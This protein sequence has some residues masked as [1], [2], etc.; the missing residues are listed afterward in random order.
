MFIAQYPDRYRSAGAAC[1][2]ALKH[3]ALRWSA[4]LLTVR[5]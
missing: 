5:L 2:L 1:K 4:E 3:M